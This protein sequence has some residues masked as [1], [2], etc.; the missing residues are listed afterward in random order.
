MIHVIETDPEIVEIVGLA[1]WTVPE[2]LFSEIDESEENKEE[3]AAWLE[4]HLGIVQLIL[5]N[6]ATVPAMRLEVERIVR[7]LA[8]TSMQHSPF[9][10][11]DDS[12]T[13]PDTEP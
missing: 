4:K 13:T 9:N 7:S 5:M 8:I 12:D 1:Q 3:I 11:L 2:R 10:S 6:T